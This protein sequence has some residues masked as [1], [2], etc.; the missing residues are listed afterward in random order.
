VADAL[1]DALADPDAYA[2][3][4]ALG[5]L[6]PSLGRSAVPAVVKTLETFQLELGAVEFELLLRFWAS[7]EPAEATRWSFKKSPPLFRI[8]GARTAVEIWGEADPAAAV[9]AVESALA[10]ASEDVARASLLALVRGWTRTDRP[11]LEKYIEGL[12]S[13]VKRQRAIYA[14][15]IALAAED[16]SDAAIRWGESVP[17][18]DRRYK[19][20]VL[21]QVT[22]AL[23]WADMDAAL[24]FCQS[25]CDGP[26]GKG[27][28]NTIIRAR[29]RSGEY[30][31]DVITWVTSA[32]EGEEEQRENK[33][34]SL[35]V[36][37][38]VWAY[39]DREAA[40]AWMAEKLEGEPEPW[41]QALM[42]EYARQLAAESPAEGI[43]WAEQVEDD[44]EREL[45][46]VRIT[47]AWMQQDPE[48]AE[49]WL[50][51]SSLS[52]TARAQARDTNKPTYLRQPPP[53]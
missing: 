22:S 24:R 15:A 43:R 20:E 48:A 51:Q 49:A 25:H 12:G 38:G 39:R 10:E 14:Y 7:H 9:V 34:H 28:R 3:A 32:P 23:T 36:A 18:D 30:G 27:L 47:R 42:G 16:G 37:Y 41:L 26:L 31:G 50:S 33:R 11:G 8:A 52:E 5:T 6:L 46:L 44:E 40:M 17:E 1:A 21:R 19:L 2:R 29:L 4:R 45:S 13:G 53:E 35:W